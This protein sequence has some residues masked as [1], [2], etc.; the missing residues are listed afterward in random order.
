MSIP[1]EDLK[2]LTDK[3]RKSL[4]D[5]RM[6]ES[7]AL[8]WIADKKKTEN[9]LKTIIVNESNKIIEAL[10]DNE[11]EFIGHL[12]EEIQLCLEQ[13]FEEAMEDGKQIDYVKGRKVFLTDS[14]SYGYEDSVNEI[15]MSRFT[16]ESSKDSFSDYNM[17]CYLDVFY[18]Y[19]FDDYEVTLEFL[20]NIEFIKEGEMISEDILEYVENKYVYDLKDKIFDRVLEDIMDIGMDDFIEQNCLYITTHTPLSTLKEQ[21]RVYGKIEEIVGDIKLIPGD[22]TLTIT[23]TSMNDSQ[24][25]DIKKDI[26]KDD[27]EL[28]NFELLLHYI[29]ASSSIAAI[30][31]RE[32]PINSTNCLVVKN[33]YGM[34]IVNGEYQWL[35]EEEVFEAMNMDNKTG[36]LLEPDPTLN[37]CGFYFK[38]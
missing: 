38:K 18:D 27:E 5:K 2:Y 24:K 20:K 34:Q 30:I 28:E 35:K 21:D 8:Q 14:T 33:I 9:E 32:T 22:K 13:A 3:Q 17:E 26:K 19:V 1:K 31:V 37:Y 23:S 10:K 7:Q 36:E 6:P 29:I 25:I 11:E 15:L 16:G 4:K 12:E